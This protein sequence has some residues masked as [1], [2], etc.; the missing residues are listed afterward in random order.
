MPDDILV[1]D[2]VVYLI[3]ENFEQSEVGF[4]PVNFG[5]IPSRLVDSSDCST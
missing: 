2:G 1:L 5:E 4:I 3:H